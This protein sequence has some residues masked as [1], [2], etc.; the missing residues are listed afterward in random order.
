MR[1]V[2]R[3]FRRLR[4][5]SPRKRKTNFVR[6]RLENLEDRLVPSAAFVQTN[7]VSDIAG[8]A[9][10]T[11]PQ[12]IN[13][14]GLTASSTSPFWV[15]DNQ[16]GL[17]T[18]YN[19]Q[20][21]KQGLVVT[22]PSASNST[23]TH[24]TPTGTVFNTDPNKS[25]FQVTA[26][27]KTASSIFLFDTLDGT[28]DGWK[29]GTSAVIAVT[30]PGAVYTGMAIDTS[31]TA[32]NTLLYAA[33]WGKGTVEVYN[34]S[35]QQVDVGAFQD[36]AI[37][38]NFRPFNVQDINGNIFV[39]YAQF[40]PTTGADTG[41]GGFVAEFT[42]DGV[43]EA[44]L[45]GDGHFNSPW[46]VALAPAGFGNLGGDLLVGNFGDGQ[47]N[48]F[49][50]ND[51]FQFVGTL[52]DG[53]GN[54]I[55]I[56]N[57][58]AI[59][60]GNGGNA[61]SPNTLFFTAGLTDAPATIFGATDGLLGSIQAVP[62]VRENAPILPNL[63]N[64]PEQMVSTVAS[65]GDQN[66]YGVA[67]VPQDFQGGGLLTPGDILV[68]NF[69]DASNSQGT[70]NQQA[71][72]STIVEI[73]PNGQQS[74]FFQGPTG[75]GLTTALGILPQGFVLVGSTPATTVNGVNTVS[76]GGLLILDS[77]GNE[78]MELSDSAL[79]QGPWDLTIHNVDATHAQ[80]FVSNVLSGT[81]TRIDLTIPKD[82]TPEVESETQIASGYAHRTDP[83]ALVVGPTGLAYDGKT[84]TLY[85]AS[86]GDNAI[87]AIKDASDTNRDQGKGQLVVQDPQ[88]LH[89]PLGLIL[90]PNGDLIAANGDAQNADPNQPNELVEYTRH[91]QFVGQF[92]ID[93]GAPGAAFG[94]A[95]QQIGDQVRFAAVDDNT[96]TLKVWTFQTTDP[97]G[98]DGFALSS[99]NPSMSPSPAPSPSDSLAQRVDAFFQSFNAALQ[100]MESKFLAMDPQLSSMAIMFN[101]DLDALEAM[102]LSTL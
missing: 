19:G 33:D 29:G 72:G 90:A 62:T 18:R 100:S 51:N 74:T 64:F 99:V 9:A 32:G 101:A 7:L 61:G 48:A 95:A 10:T 21:V 52:K 16:V 23:F 93:S 24:P 14:W 47:I 86:T 37:P 3:A 91:G 63:I 28:I 43:L 8:M 39:T 83:N 88:H 57:L 102:I 98:G 41:T 70:G 44:T 40:D 96:N 71:T 6:P 60:F 13:P 75:L 59:R 31:S 84:D 30:N 53:A 92:Q 20:G 81:V 46:G 42:R 68:S 94:L 36:K 12:L 54:P 49:N 56:G 78:I 87:Y 11:D 77:S 58:W 80:V 79:L 5:K 1:F 17:S 34:G 69:N 38:S 50:P 2:L 45:K 76:N 27:G 65:N 73:G 55:T 35:F 85:V 97:P 15:S 82:G 4:G 66:P 26:G 67:F 89:G 22:I 25:D